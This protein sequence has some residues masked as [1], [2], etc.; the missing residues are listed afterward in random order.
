MPSG[1]VLFAGTPLII[2]TGDGV[3]I[4]LCARLLQLVFQIVE[5]GLGVALFVELRI[6]RYARSDRGN[7]EER[8]AGTHP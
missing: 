6:Y 7:T 2:T 3:A 8:L 4:Y 1:L 5:L